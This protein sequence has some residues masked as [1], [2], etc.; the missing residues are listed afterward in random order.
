MGG[1]GVIISQQTLLLLGPWLDRCYQNETLTPHEDVELGRCILQHVGIDCTKAYDSKDLFHHEYT[2]SFDFDSNS[3][4]MKIVRSLMVHPVMNEKNFRQLFAF[5]HGESKKKH[6]SSNKPIN[7]TVGF[8][9]FVP[10]VSLDVDRDSQI[11]KFDLRWKNVFERLTIYYI[12][13]LDKR[14]F[15]SRR[16]WTIH[17]AQPIFGYYRFDPGKRFEIIIE[18]LLELKLKISSKD[19]LRYA[20]KRLFFSQALLESSALRKLITFF[21]HLQQYFHSVY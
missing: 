6:F 2:S 3:S 13:S 17:R 19:I 9:T 1:S 4:S 12:E 5:F 7:K 11:G 21:I 10:N 14:W 15:E 16:N 20:R 8:K 18:I